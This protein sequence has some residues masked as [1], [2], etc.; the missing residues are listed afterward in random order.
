MRISAAILLAV[1]VAAC[2]D[3][4]APPAPASIAASLSTASGIAGLTLTTTPSF[5]VRAADG[6][7]LGGVPVSISVTSGGGTLTNAPAATL[8]GAPTPVGEWTLGR[9]A[10][11]NTLTVAVGEL[12]PLLISV[13]GVPGPLASIVAVAGD[14][15]S[16]FAGTV[17]S[18]PLAVQLRDQFGNGVPSTP[19]TVLAAPGSGV[20]T[21]STLTTAA[22][23]TASGIVWQLAK[24]AV[25]HIAIVSS[26]AF[27]A[28]L[29]ATVA[30][31]F[32]VDL[33]FYGPAPSGEAAAAFLEAAARVKATIIGDIPD[34]D[35]P[36]LRNNA[37]LDISGCG[38]SGTVVNE[39]IDD[40]IIYASVVPIDGL[41]KVVASA[42]PCVIRGQSRMAMI[43]VMKFDVADIGDLISSHHLGDVILHEMLHVVGFG[44]IWT[45]SRRPGGILLT[46]GG[47]DNPRFT[48]SLGIS[49]CGSAGGTGACN[50]GVA[51]EGL[52]FGP[53]TADAHWRE[54]IFDTEVMT[55]FIE[56]ADIPMAFSAMTIQSLA[57]AGY[58]VNLSAGDLYFVPL[59]ASLSGP[60]RESRSAIAGQDVQWEIVGE[61]ML[62]ISPSGQLRQTRSR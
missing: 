28:T 4:T 31:D 41:G 61:P 43:G 51:V 9:T 33:R 21:P 46:G 40:V 38:P 29:T 30:S 25:S 2:T 54:S 60:G 5:A 36:T 48:G 35:L 17:L 24:S 55:G 6:R 45:D 18:T 16:G 23:G 56:T 12:P 8:N 47:T 11:A 62:E 15:Q 7:I 26:G 14:G 52:P 37:G 3:T 32:N 44:T 22:D 39:V 27:S 19:V 50:G 53:G 49:A 10:G 13:T 1:V 42:A 59:S 20:I 34:V 58:I 57:D